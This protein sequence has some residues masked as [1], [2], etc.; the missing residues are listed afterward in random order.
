VIVRILKNW[1]VDDETISAFED[2]VP[3]PPKPDETTEN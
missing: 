3:D 2:E 1:E